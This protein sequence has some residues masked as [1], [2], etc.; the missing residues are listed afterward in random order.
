MIEEEIFSAL[1]GF[2]PVFAYIAPA[3]QLTPYLV[4]S[5]ITENKS[6]VFCGQAETAS[7]FQLDS[8]ALQP[9]QA[10]KN[11]NDAFS[12]LSSLMPCNVSCGGSY[13]EETGFYR[14]QIEFTIIT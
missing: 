1:K 14:Y 2:L 5:T 3:N 7:V 6:D 4:Y 9:G 11:A 12:L 13:E 8:Y 10:K